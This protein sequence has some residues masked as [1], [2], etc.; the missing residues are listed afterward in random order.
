M[1]EATH[2][3]VSS[4]SGLAQEISAGAHRWNKSEIDIQTSIVQTRIRL[5]INS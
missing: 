4:E 1:A 2:V 3:T 5:N